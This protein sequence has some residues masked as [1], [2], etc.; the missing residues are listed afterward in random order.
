MRLAAQLAGFGGKGNLDPGPLDRALARVRRPLDRV[1]ERRALSLD[2]LTALCRA[3]DADFAGAGARQGGPRVLVASLRGWS[4]HNAY[5][6]AIAQAL[7]LRGADVALLTC[8]GGLPVCELGSARKAYPRPCD[9]CAWLTERVA[10]AAG[11]KHY[12]LSAN[13]P[14]GDDAREAPTV[15]REEGIGTLSDA[16]ANAAWLLKASDL[17]RVPG[18]QAVASDFAVTA[19]GAGRAAG[20]ILDDFQPELV[21]ML[22]GLFGPERGIREAAL[23][24]GVRTPS[25]EV[26]PRGGA[27][28]FS[29]DAPAP[30]YDVDELWAA[31][32]DRPLSDTQ[33][34]EV[35]G[36]LADRRRGVGAH[37][38][39]YDGVADS[40]VA[41]RRDLG[42]EQ[43]RRVASL[44][45][46]VT[47]DSATVGHDIG[48]ESMF[49]WVEQAVRL[50]SESDMDLVVRIHP[51]EGRWGT[52]EDVREVVTSRV[53]EMPA[54]VRFVTAA[55]PISSYALV[56]I[57]DLVLA[58]TTTVGLEAA[59]QGKRVGVAGDTHYRGRGFTIDLD[60]PQDLADI[61]AGEPAPL[62]QES[63]ELAIRYAH[64]FFFRA[65]IPFPLIEARD[66]KVLRFPERAAEL[67][68]GADPYLD[69]VCERI[70]DGGHFGLPDELAG[71]PRIDAAA[72]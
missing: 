57:S 9:R 35:L 66:G 24:R 23:A 13:L 6:L 59:V 51:A 61:L 67:A 29:Q 7:R 5:E 56:E 18:A 60:G 15:S 38:S 19:D 20:A 8:G 33:R 21:F 34:A 48:F 26:A 10:A 72:A 27:L 54:N 17:R 22:N 45:T 32:G 69:W 28:V 46:N 43:G 70:L 65:M 37:E 52:R 2:S 42:L 25:Y 1:Y 44:F 36:L 62:A 63:V 3:V 16:S 41:I 30:D 31:V 40:P 50:M 55:D 68:P 4:S 14:W 49:D 53:G 58:Y 64:M 39:Y 71:I 47:W 12:R 11:M